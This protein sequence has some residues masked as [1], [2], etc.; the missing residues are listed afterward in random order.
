MM[1]ALVI[2]LLMSLIVM[3]IVEPWNDTLGNPVFMTF[4]CFCIGGAVF[5]IAILIFIFT[6]KNH[7]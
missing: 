2:Y 3:S 7:G 1:W 5:I 6:E 4:L